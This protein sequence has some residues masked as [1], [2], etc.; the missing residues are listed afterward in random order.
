TS[1]TQT[2]KL[3]RLLQSPFTL[4][5]GMIERLQRE[6]EH[7]R[8]GRPARVICKMNSLVD[9]QA[10]EA[11]YR[12]SGAGVK[13]DLIVRGICALRPGLPG[14]SENITVRSVVG[15]FPGPSA[16]FYFA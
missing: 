13:V 9:P 12:A 6:A 1:L 8:A 5:T 10:I 16:V 15:R 7:A 14:V 11:L 2:P 4:H 3:N